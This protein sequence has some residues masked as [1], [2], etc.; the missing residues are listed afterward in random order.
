MVGFALS[1]ITRKNPLKLIPE[2]DFGLIPP[3]NVTPF[4]VFDFLKDRS[5]RP[6]GVLTVLERFRGN[7]KKNNPRRRSLLKPG[8]DKNRQVEPRL[9]YA[10]F[11]R[12]QPG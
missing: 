1:T 6:E 11:Q 12:R 10:P 2:G 9:L 4:C 7:L 5:M 8:V 3:E